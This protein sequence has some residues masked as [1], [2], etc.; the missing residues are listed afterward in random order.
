ME[1]D[2]MLEVAM[3]R[4]PHLGHFRGDVSV[5]EGWETEVLFLRPLRRG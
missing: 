5:E 3:L 1:L 2:I 4:P